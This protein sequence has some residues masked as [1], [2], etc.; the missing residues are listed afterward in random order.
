MSD[1]AKDPL[2]MAAARKHIETCKRVGIIDQQEADDLVADLQ[3]EVLTPFEELAQ[4]M[5]PKPAAP[6]ER[7][8]SYLRSMMGLPPLPPKKSR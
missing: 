4:H 8:D 2:R 5:Q 1:Y 7:R 3:S 6:T